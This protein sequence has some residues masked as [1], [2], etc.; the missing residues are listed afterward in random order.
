MTV[1][2]Y[3]DWATSQ[4]HADK[5]AATGVPLLTKSTNV[6][7]DVNHSIPFGG[8]PVTIANALVITQIGYEINVTA[9][10][11]AA[12]PTLP[13]LTVDMIWT[14]TVGAETV[15]H[16]QW[17]IPIGS[18][19]IGSVHIGTGPSKG[20]RLTV[21]LSNNDSAQNATVTTIIN[22]NSRVYVRDDWRTE[23]FN[24]IPNGTTPLHEQQGNTL[25]NFLT[26]VG[27]LGSNTR[28]LPLYAGKITIAFGSTISKSGTLQVNNLDPAVN[29]ASIY[30]LLPIP[31]GSNQTLLAAVA[32]PRAACQFTLADT[33]NAANT[34]QAMFIIDEYLG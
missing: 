19:G 10:I 4:D 29:A 22:Q 13:I 8:A 20:N 34:L 14:D 5:I 27:A 26:N 23:A 24:T 16:E 7:N 17:N 33:S 3:P 25:A 2:D 15:S 6:L 11:S 31:N 28:I 1:T 21:Q 30:L 9:K 32:L 18:T 12:A